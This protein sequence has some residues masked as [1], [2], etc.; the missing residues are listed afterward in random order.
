MLSEFPWT[1]CTI[2]LEKPLCKKWEVYFMGLQWSAYK[3]HLC[4]AGFSIHSPGYIAGAKGETGGIWNRALE[5]NINTVQLNHSE[6]FLLSVKSI[7]LFEQGMVP[8]GS[9][10][11]EAI[12]VIHYLPSQALILGLLYP[13]P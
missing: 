2:A 3:L 9:A 10:C 12:I 6:V 11:P 13:Q 5:M 4:A 8:Q 7:G 1:S